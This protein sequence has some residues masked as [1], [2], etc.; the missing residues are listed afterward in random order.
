[1]NTPFKPLEHSLR[2][3]EEFAV[4]GDIVKFDIETKI[5]Y[6]QMDVVGSYRSWMGERA[7]EMTRH[8]QSRYDQIKLLMGAKK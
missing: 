7:I 1:M 5:F 3:L 8:Y 6:L 2:R 4:K